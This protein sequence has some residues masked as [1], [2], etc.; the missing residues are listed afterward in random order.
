[1]NNNNS[2]SK[3]N[4]KNEASGQESIVASSIYSSNSISNNNSVS[5]FHTF[6]IDRSL[7]L[8]SLVWPFDL[9]YKTTRVKMRCVLSC[10]QVGSIQ[11]CSLVCV[12]VVA[13]M[14]FVVIIFH[15][16]SFLVP[17]HPSLAFLSSLFF[18]IICFTLFPHLLSSTTSSHFIL[19]FLPLLFSFSSFL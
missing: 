17:P 11:S 3:K 18:F 10:V 2:K 16:S 14:A 4:K 19:A 7:H 12:H 6:A 9:I 13:L 8:H 5:L 1:M 15:F